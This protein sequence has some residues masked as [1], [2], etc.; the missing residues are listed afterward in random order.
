M[1][2]NYIDWKQW[3]ADDF[4]K[5]DLGAAE[6]FSAELRACGIRSVT[7]LCIGELGYGNGAFAGWVRANGGIW[8]GSEA[9]SELRSR[10][11]E[12]GFAALAP[13]TDFSTS[14]GAAT[15][16]AMFAFDVLE[17]LPLTDIRRFLVDAR[18]AL[19]PGGL[20]AFRVPSGDSP[21]SGAIFRGDLTHITLLGSSAVRQLAADAHMELVHVREPVVPIIWTNPISAIRRFGLRA[22]QKL[23]YWFVRNMLMSNSAAIISPNMFVV[24]RKRIADR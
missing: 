21:Y 2:D 3:N 6:Y 18:E 5:F 22:A 14:L 16:D 24:L 19:R 7:G 15:I 9:R 10:A 11:I 12:A 23:A 17:H 1:S 20:I 8:M 13:D 4:G